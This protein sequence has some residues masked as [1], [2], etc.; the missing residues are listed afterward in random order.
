MQDKIIVKG[1]RE[2][3]LKNIS[4]EFPKNKLIVFTGVSGS[5]KSSMAFDTLFAEG[6][7][8]YVESLSS[9]ARQFLGNLKRPEV[10]LIEGLSPSVAINQ[11]AISHN[12]RSTVGTITEIYDY[13]RLLYARIGHPHCPNCG[14]EVI[15]QTSKQIV[16]QILNIA[17]TNINSL[18]S[19]RFLILAPIVQNKSG[20]FRGL[21]DNLRK[22]GY[23]WARVDQQIID[24]YSEYSIIKTNKHNIDVVIDRVVLTKQ[25]FKT[26]DFI[27]VSYQRLIDDVESAMKLSNGLLKVSQIDDPSFEFPDQPKK[28]IDTLYSENYACPVCNISLPALEPALFSFNSP[29]GACLE[30]KGLGFKFEID[31]SKFPEWKAKMLESKYFNSDSEI[32]RDQLQRYMSKNICPTCNASRLNPEALSVTVL[33]KNISQICQ[34]PIDQLNSWIQNLSRNIESNKESEILD[35]IVNELNSRLEFLL[36]VGLEYLSL[37]REAGTLSSGESQ[38]IRLASQIGTGLTGV[39]YIL[40]EPTIGLHSRDNDRLISTLKKLRDIGNTVIVVEHDEDVIKNADYIVDFGKYAGNNGGT[41]VAQGELSDLKNQ[42]ESLTAK[43]IYKKLTVSHTAQVKQIPLTSNKLQIHGAS[44][45]N[46]KNINVDIPLN[47]FVCVTGVSGSGKSTLVHDTIYAGVKKK[48][49]G[50]YFDTIGTFK[51]IEGWQDIKD[52]LLVDQSPIG[53]TPRSNPATY[54]KIFDEI[55]NL[56]SQTTEAQ[57]RGFNSGRFSFNVKGGR[58][59]TCQGQGQIKIEMQFLPDIYVTCDQCHGSRYKD[60]TLEVVYKNKNIAE[61]LNMTIDE[62]LDFFKNIP[63]LRR[64]LSTVLEVGLGY[65][66]LGQPS[67]T[68]SGGESQRLKISREL[69]KR[70]KEH[71]LYILDEPTT[72]LHFYDVDKLVKV[73]RKLVELGNTVLLIEHNL[74]VIKNADWIIDMGPEGGQKGGEIIAQGTIEDIKNTSKSYTGQYLKRI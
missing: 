45:W 53:R 19:Y 52:V 66:Q 33:Q 7:R 2:H 4:F 13:L 28:L 67:N 21:M 39:L 10:D 47:K 32:I 5:G 16:T 44:Q 15:P 69:V 29:Q 30:C 17:K 35:P 56:I 64:K 43:Y 9:Y 40:D 14:R 55:R 20:D 50:S 73:L 49:Y 48:I 72:G 26:K 63:S 31:R 18:T 57:I 71:T 46:L 1:A 12:P 61:I 58:C 27:Q 8:R 42:P 68:L 54:T 11:K 62:A 38:R 6:Q 3:N 41:I 37:D 65:L 59:E 70:K 25:N 60:E 23:K 36:A 51:D 24:L 34:L 22:Q 74:D